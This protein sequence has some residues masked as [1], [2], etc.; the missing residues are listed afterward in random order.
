MFSPVS[1]YD[2]L[3]RLMI[4]VEI[5]ARDLIHYNT[6]RWKYLSVRPPVMF[7][8]LQPAC[9]AHVGDGGGSPGEPAEGGLRDP[10]PLRH[11]HLLPPHQH[12]HPRGRQVRDFRLLGKI[13]KYKLTENKQM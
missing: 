6:V 4:M 1:R 11:Q 8:L 7:H 3:Q 9:Q 10:G 13:V 12:R 2:V 5:T